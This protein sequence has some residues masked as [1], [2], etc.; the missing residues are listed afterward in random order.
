MGRSV[1]TQKR[2]RIAAAAQLEHWSKWKASKLVYAEESDPTIAYQNTR[3][4]YGRY[5]AEIET[6]C[7]H[8]SLKEAAS[9]LAEASSSPVTKTAAISVTE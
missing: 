5:N 2:V 1:K 7:K 3:I 4:F 8:L 6:E 9:I